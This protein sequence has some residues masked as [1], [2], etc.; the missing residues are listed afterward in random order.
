MIESVA[1]TDIL[2]GKISGRIIGDHPAIDDVDDDDGTIQRTTAQLAI[3]VAIAIYVFRKACK[4]IHDFHERLNRSEAVAGFPS[5]PDPH[6]LVGHF[7]ILRGTELHS[8]KERKSKA[9]K[10]GSSEIRV[11]EDEDVESTRVSTSFVRGYQRV[12]CD[13]ADQGTGMGSFW[14]FHIPCVSVL[15]G[16]DAKKV[17]GSSSFRKPVWLTNIHTRQLLGHKTLLSLMNK[18]WRYYRSAIHKSFTSEVIKQSR[19]F[20]YQIG[21]TLADALLTKIAEK[22]FSKEKEDETISDYGSEDET[23][24]SS[25]PLPTQA[26]ACMIGPISVL[27]LMKM[28]TIDV[29]GLVALGGNGVDFGCTRNLELSPIAS[30]FDHLT[31]EYTARLKRPWDPFS[32]LYSL[33]TKSNRDYKRKR[34]EI[35]NFVAEQIMQTRARITEKRTSKEP[36]HASQ[37]DRNDMLTNLIKVADS[38]RVKAQRTMKVDDRAHDEAL[39]D[40]LMTLLFAGYD[41]TSI[42]LT[43]ALYLLAKNPTKKAKCLV[44][45]DTVL[46]KDFDSYETKRKAIGHILPP[47]PEELPYTKGVILEALRLFPPAPST[48]RMIEKPTTIGGSGSKRARL[49]SSASDTNKTATNSNIKNKT[50]TLA[51][52]QMV[53]IPIWSIQRSELNYPRPNEMIPERWVRRKRQMR[54]ASDDADAETIGYNS[55][56]S[57]WEVRPE[58]DIHK[59]HTTVDCGTTNKANECIKIEEKEDD[60]ENSI[61]P[62]NR[63]AFCS[64]AAGARNCVGKRLALDKS[65]ILL[66]CLVHKLS[67]ELIS[68]TYEV[69]PSLHALVQQPDDDLPMIVRPR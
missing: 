48:A 28:A 12:Y 33:P 19:P 45:I 15:K 29:F 11:I 50:F 51:T 61:A 17:M 34:S 44:E 21:N 30:A 36:R 1:A 47:G 62:A 52:G 69:S 37:M 23:V 2:Y 10:T 41:T 42:A 26:N 18:E 60:D 14:F 24:T 8:V 40:I 9:A 43:Y 58:D 64:F 5:R 53:M 68:D 59:E 63:D 7:M 32:F 3:L 55:R 49:S 66:A 22:D 54:N 27:P 46:G 39:I 13:H 6:W 25:N 65:V 57:L 56:I 35:R 38:E 4:M 67:F 20:I 16:K 31:T